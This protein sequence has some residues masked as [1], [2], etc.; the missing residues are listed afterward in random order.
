MFVYLATLVVAVLLARLAET[1]QASLRNELPRK[2]NLPA[3]L[4]ALTLIFVSALRW[5]V[6]SDYWNYHANFPTYAREFTEE[7]S[8]FGEPGI[9]FLAWL[10]MQIEDDSATMFALAALVTIGLIVRTLWRWSPAFAFSVALYI[11]IGAW[12]DSFNGVRQFL[13]AAVLFAGHRYVINRELWKWLA[14]VFIG[15]LFHISAL[16][17]LLL[18]FIPR[19]KTSFAIQSFI[20]VLGFIGMFSLDSL[21]EIL[22][23]IDEE[24]R[25]GSSYAAREVNPFRIAFAFVP[26]AFYWLLANKKSI[27]SNN[28]W[29]YVN[30]L[31]VYGAT[32]LTSASSALVA[33]FAIYATP[34]AILGLVAVTSVEDKRERAII[35]SLVILVYGVFFYIDTF[36]LVEPEPFRWIFERP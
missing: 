16:V 34:F 9:R 22:S 28:S 18:Y 30:M 36:A 2:W 1:H 27:E 11:L 19:R 25:W 6:G 8:I 26:L 23:G 10:G 33:R 5:G 24:G 31:A 17:A 15:M 29:F 3:L 32:F 21:I 14:I 12:S 20:V 4:V 7:F 35:R 13:A